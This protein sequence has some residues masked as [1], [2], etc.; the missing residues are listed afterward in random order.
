MNYGFY[1]PSRLVRKMGQSVEVKDAPRNYK[2][3]KDSPMIIS[4]QFHSVQGSLIEQ[5]QVYLFYN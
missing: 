2:G 4:N 1:N 5:S 3:C